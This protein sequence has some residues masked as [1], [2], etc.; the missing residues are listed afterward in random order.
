LAENLKLDLLVEKL[1]T[2]TANSEDILVAIEEASILGMNYLYLSLRR[3]DAKAIL[4]LH[5]NPFNG[6]LISLIAMI[7]IGCGKHSPSIEEANKLAK[8]LEGLIMVVGECSYILS[9]YDGSKDIAEFLSDIFSKIAGDSPG[10][11]FLIEGYS[12]DLFTT[13]SLALQ[14]ED[15]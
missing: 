8:S 9:G 13:E 1:S 11:K 15:G 14:G 10:D 2:L 7:P 12:Y 6:D 3:G 4:A 5:I